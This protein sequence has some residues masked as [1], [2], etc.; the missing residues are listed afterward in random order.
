MVG[1][2]HF[3]SGLDGYRVVAG[4]L[5]AD[6]F[7]RQGLEQTGT[8]DVIQLLAL[9]RHGLDAQPRPTV[10]F[11]RLF[12]APLSI[13]PPACQEAVRSA[14]TTQTFDSSALLTATSR[15]AIAV[16]VTVDSVVEP[17]DLA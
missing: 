11:L 2:I 9:R 4:H 12:R 17:I 6:G 16:A 10:L 13:A 8:Q 3:P 15:L 7:V 1:H 5:V 14:M